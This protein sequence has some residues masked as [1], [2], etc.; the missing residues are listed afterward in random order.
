MLRS[1][2]GERCQML[3]VIQAVGASAFRLKAGDGS[4]LC[5]GERFPP[6]LRGLQVLNGNLIGRCFEK[7]FKVRFQFHLLPPQLFLGTIFN[8]FVRDNSRCEQTQ[9]N[10]QL[11]A[12]HPTDPTSPPS[13]VPRPTS[14]N[15]NKW[16][17]APHP[18]STVQPSWPPA[19]LPSRA[20]PTTRSTRSF[21][22]PSPD[23][24]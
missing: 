12:H 18:S 22:P 21:A 24:E 13:S 1:Q 5:F 16:T 17:A 3:Q 20:P 23:A 10:D 8:I 19:A 9:A 2:F 6:F 15:D 7:K 14:T 4:R 11:N